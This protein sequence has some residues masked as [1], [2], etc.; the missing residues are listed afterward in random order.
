MSLISLPSMLRVPQRKHRAL[1]RIEQLKAEVADKSRRLQA[2]DKLISQILREKS[3]TYLDLRNVEQQLA[4][5]EG[6]IAVQL[7]QIQALRAEA[8]RPARRITVQA[9]STSPTA[10]PGQR[11]A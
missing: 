6:L 7:K 10:I 3:A 5:A 4:C 1:D 11:T 8:A 2:A 9:G